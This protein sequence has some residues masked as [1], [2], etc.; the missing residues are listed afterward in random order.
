MNLL[1]TQPPFDTPH[2]NQRQFTSARGRRAPR[3]C[4][5]PSWAKAAVADCSYPCSHGSPPPPTTAHPSREQTNTES[6]TDEGGRHRDAG[7]DGSLERSGAALQ[8]RQT[9]RG[10]A[11]APATT[12]SPPGG[13]RGWKCA[14]VC[15]RAIAYL[16]RATHLHP[17]LD[18]E[19]VWHAAETGRPARRT[20]SGSWS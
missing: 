18:I 17:P 13:L 20:E 10:C 6:S 16:S 2:E 1:T 12:P 15:V 8:M 11:R 9:R 3:K 4:S 14:C 19:E 5:S 7:L